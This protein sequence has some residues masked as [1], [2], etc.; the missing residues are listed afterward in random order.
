MLYHGGCHCGSVRFSFRTEVPPPEW[1]IRACQ[2]SFCRAHGAYTTS[3]P[4]GSL[5]FEV[6]AAEPLRFY[7]FG[8]RI[9]DFLVCRECGVYVG[10][11]TEVSGMLYAIINTNALQP[12][13]TGLKV[14]MPSV[15]DDESAEARI[16]RRQRLWTPC[17]GVTAATGLGGQ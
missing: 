8:R 4:K 1:A 12:R 5:E 14:P 2:C 15:Y 9:T 17:R 11:V 3:D 13:Q 16:Q 6:T 7:R 10:A